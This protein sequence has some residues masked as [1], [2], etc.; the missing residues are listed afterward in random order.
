MTSNEYLDLV[1]KYAKEMGYYPV[2]YIGDWQG[3][4]IFEPVKNL[5][6]VYIGYPLVIL[7]KGLKFRISTREESL[8][9]MNFFNEE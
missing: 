3:Y 4:H 7:E 6:P 2:N 8:K 1:D 5:E 9:I